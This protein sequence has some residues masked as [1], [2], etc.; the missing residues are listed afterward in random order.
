MKNTRKCPKCGNED[1]FLIKGYTGAYGTG[2]NVE[3]GKSIF[4]AIPV[5]RYVC[6]RCGYSEEWI[7]TED[8]RK[9]RKS[10]HAEE[11]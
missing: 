6:S 11:L 10:K 7:R 1:I 3:V 5:D 8:I 9:L 2:N 4:S